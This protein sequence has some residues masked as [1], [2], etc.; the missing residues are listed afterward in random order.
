MADAEPQL[1]T[2]TSIVPFAATGAAAAL[3]ALVDDRMRPDRL[4]HFPAESKVGSLQMQQQ[5]GAALG[6]YVWT[7]GVHLT[8][9]VETAFKVKGLRVLE[10]GSGTGVTAIALARLG[11]RVTAT[12]SL[13]QLVELIEANISLNGLGAGRCKATRFAWG[14][15]L[16]ETLLA[17]LQLVLGS[18]ITYN[19]SGFAPLVQTLRE[20]CEAAVGRP[21]PRILLAE[22]LRNA[23][24]PRFWDLA[25]SHFFAR[26][27]AAFPQQDSWNV[28]D[29]QA[30]VRIFE[31]RW[32]GGSSSDGIPPSLGGD[33]LPPA[34]VGC[35]VVQTVDMA[36]DALRSQGACVLRGCG[37]GT[38]SDAA[39][40]PR[41]LFG[42]SL[43]AAPEPAEISD[44]VLARRGIRKADEFRAHTD[45][46]AYGDLFPDM[47]LLI[48]ERACTLHGGGNYLIDGYR[49]LDHLAAD[50]ATA[51]VPSALEA[52]LV[53]QT[54]RLPSV[55]PV[56]MRA[57]DGRR[58]LRCR[59]SGPP[60][61]FAAQRP[62]ADSDDPEAD[63]RMLAAYHAAVEKAA[64][65]APRIVLKPGDALIV[66]NYRMF[67]G[68]DSFCDEQRLLW[69]VWI[70]TDGARGVPEGQ[71]VSTPGDTA[72]TVTSD[73]APQA[74]Q[75]SLCVTSGPLRRIG[76]TLLRWCA[77]SKASQF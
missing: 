28:R 40:L 42:D 59:L 23:R 44:R 57:P 37:H 2:C 4:V 7:A 69:R 1:S 61:A 38:C 64:G 17:P 39:L 30:P 6:A 5:P 43:R 77:P 3:Q 75:A 63:A 15:P 31:L 25:G 21:A 19:E 20:L 26:E 49:V 45:G 52:R 65:E 54:S 29:K 24:Q 56:V 60:A 32:R 71:L 72:G 33:P 58:A 70:W 22:T 74:S 73:A 18:E 34:G 14:E 16:Q 51:W 50:P 27:V 48:C 10:L 12:D 13:P 67:H 41:Q 62:A 46:H 11:A 9:Y 68:R 8:C 36:R 47:F 35:P 55:T 53:D 66:D 76:A